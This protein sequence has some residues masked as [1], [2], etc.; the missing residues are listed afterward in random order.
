MTPS[1]AL[2][3]LL[4][5]ACAYA[6]GARLFLS[7]R[8]TPASPTL[9]DPDR[10]LLVL[11]GAAVGAALG[12]KLAFWL[13]DPA[14]AFAQFPTLANL[15]VGKSIVGGLLGGLVGV[16][17]TKKLLRQTASTGDDI[18]VP[19]AVG[20]A[21]G[22]LGCFFAGLSDRTYGLPTT[23]PWGV[24]FG[25]G[26]ARHPTQLYEIAFVLAWIAFVL[27]RRRGA[28][29]PAGD[30]FKAFLCGYL[31]FRLAVEAIKPAPHLYWPGLT[32]IQWLCIA[33]LAYHARHL[34]RLVRELSWATR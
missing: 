33:G 4:F 3:H 14:T 28:A 15:L 20:M 22:R 17:L 5:E 32:G 29:W 23:L 19:L 13:E 9:A 21:I 8:R 10:R 34:P 24:D 30:A 18:V 27:H 6:V 31:L 26:I 16:E 7:H 25:D 2:V 12:S 1:P 11:V